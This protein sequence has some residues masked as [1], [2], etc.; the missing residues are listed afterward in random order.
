MG[1]SAATGRGS[2]DI[3]AGRGQDSPTIYSSSG[4]ATRGIDEDISYEE[5]D[6]APEV[7]G[8]E[9]NINEGDPDFINDLSR[10]Y[11]SMLTNADE[12]FDIQIVDIDESGEGPAVVVKSSQVRLL[13]R[14]DLKIHVGDPD[15][16][17]SVVIKSD[18]HMIFIPG[19]GGV[20]KLGGED[21]DRAILCTD[22][23]QSVSGGD[24]GTVSSTQIGTTA[25]GAIGLGESTGFG[26]Y[27]T[28][29]LIK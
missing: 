28:K 25:M 26:T 23:T 21:A 3:V 10:I 4:L 13:A 7:T 22:G 9:S 27:A 11:V 12:N 15:T 8:A 29:V 5:I 24:S 17:A 18:G 14:D 1:T 19:T 6:K 2:I 16:G 20:I